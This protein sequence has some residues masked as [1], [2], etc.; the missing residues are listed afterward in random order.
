MRRSISLFCSTGILV[1]ASISFGQSVYSGFDK[2]DYP[3][4]T[5]L[6][7]LRKSFRYTSYWL[8][9]PPGLDH[10][11]W[12]G[13]RSL[14]KQHGLVFL[15]LFNGRLHSELQGKDAVAFGGRE[16]NAAVDSAI[17]EGFPR[18]VRIYL[19]QEE[20]G[21]CYLTKPR[22]SLHGSLRLSDVER[23]REFIVR[24]LM[25]PMVPAISIRRRISSSWKAKSRGLGANPDRN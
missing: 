15:V 2:N 1:F 12:I 4:D 5:S 10:N 13:K 25:F 21:D 3:G 23:V 18:D 9:N 8:N 11:P 17:R 22:M 6:A 14:I 20:G 19:D 7:V 24:Q 16:G